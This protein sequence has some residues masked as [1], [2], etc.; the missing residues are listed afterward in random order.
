MKYNVGDRVQIK[1]LDWYNE[2]KDE[3][4]NIDINDYFTFYADRSK[5]C[6][7]VFT[8]AEVFD[9]CYTVKEDNNEYFWIDEMIEHLVAA[10]G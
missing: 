1:S 10:R 5:Y 8:I 2:N 9:D 3:Y 6:G 7:K 4:G